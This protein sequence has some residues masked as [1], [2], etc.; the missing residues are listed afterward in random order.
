MKRY[1]VRLEAEERV[2]LEKRVRGGYGVLPYVVSL[3][4][5]ERA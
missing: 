5:L 2:R 1:V 4:S 3:T